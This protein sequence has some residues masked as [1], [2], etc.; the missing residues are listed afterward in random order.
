M[1]DID[2][3]MACDILMK[4]HFGHRVEK[5]DPSTEPRDFYAGIGPLQFGVVLVQYNFGDY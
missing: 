5:Y 1:V 3:T 2:I 4:K